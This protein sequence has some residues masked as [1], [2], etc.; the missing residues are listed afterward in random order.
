MPKI[1]ISYRRTDSDATGR[2]YDR[3]V[4]RYGTETVFR[5]I[6][7]IP[8]GFDFRNAIHDAL[9]D[10]DILLAIIGPNWRGVASDGSSRI[11]EAND[12]VRI[13]I[14]TALKRNIPVIPVLIGGSVMPKPTELPESLSEFSFRNAATIDSGRNFVH[15]IERLMRSMDETMEEADKARAQKQAA[16]LQE[17]ADKERKQTEDQWHKMEAESSEQ[18]RREKKE[19]ERRERET[20]DVEA[21]RKV[22]DEYKRRE[23]RRRKAQALL[24][25]PSPHT[26]AEQTATSLWKLVLFPWLPV[27]M[28]S[29][30]K[31]LTLIGATG[32]VALAIMVVLVAGLPGIAHFPLLMWIFA[33]TAILFLCCATGTYFKSR[34]ASLL[35]FIPQIVWLGVLYHLLVFE[36][37]D[38]MLLGTLSCIFFLLSWVAFSGVKG[39]FHIARYQYDSGEQT[40][41]SRT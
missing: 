2:I 4:Q 29:Q 9:T 31:W 27:Q 34:L 18:K 41:T 22:H 37:G 21:I 23:E 17:Q 14:E 3:L 7:T 12:L 20:G 24:R 30:A 16:A 11:N 36:G 10:T 32:F 6:D 26:A 25:E 33:G 40:K 15:D 5:D 39:T 19:R 28:F 13:E 8:F 1:A 35:G 38:V